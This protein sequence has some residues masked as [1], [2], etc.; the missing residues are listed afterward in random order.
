MAQNKIGFDLHSTIARSAGPNQANVS[1]WLDLK[2][3][4]MQYPD[5]EFHWEVTGPI[6]VY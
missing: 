1:F 6:W 4:F 3:Q 5:T 2:W